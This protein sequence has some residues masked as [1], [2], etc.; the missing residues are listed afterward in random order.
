[1]TPPPRTDDRPVIVL[2]PRPLWGMLGPHKTLRLRPTQSP[3]TN[4]VSFFFYTIPF[5]S[6]LSAVVFV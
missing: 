4:L 2:S 3:I 5:L 6:P 1:M